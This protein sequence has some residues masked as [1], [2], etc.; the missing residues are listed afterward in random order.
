MNDHNFDQE[1]YPPHGYETDYDAYPRAPLSGT[2]GRSGFLGKMGFSN[3]GGL[4]RLLGVG[5]IL[6]A[7][8]VL[9]FTVWRFVNTS[10]KDLIPVIAPPSG[11]ERE[12][13]EDPGGLQIDD[14]G[15]MEEEDQEKNVRLAPPP[16][17][18]DRHLL[19]EQHEAFERHRLEEEKQAQL[20]K[21]REEKV[22]EEAKAKKEEKLSAREK[23]KSH[24]KSSLS[25]GG[26]K[27]KAKEDVKPE[28]IVPEETAGDS[29]FDLDARMSSLSSENKSHKKQSIADSSKVLSQQV[30]AGHY[31]IQ[32][33][34]YKTEDEALSKWQDFLNKDAEDFQSH[35]PV[36]IEVQTKHGSLYRLRTGGFSSSDEAKAFCASIK[37]FNIPCNPVG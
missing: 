3:S 2:E 24:S 10:H 8:I 22:A 31:E 12:R 37:S 20:Q 11:P 33:A 19:E 4:W 27:E 18:P 35:N 9:G 29:S 13:P 16:E 1:D 14:F 23:A 30:N 32:I 17:T 21:E 6:L 15:S 28:A 25:D 7:L 34:A 36:V 5:F 26:V